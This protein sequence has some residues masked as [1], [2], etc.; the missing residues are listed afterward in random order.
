V[1]HDPYFREN[2]LCQPAKTLMNL[3]FTNKA[4]SG[5]KIQY[6]IAAASGLPFN[7]NFALQFSSRCV[8]A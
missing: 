1:Q 3:G 7:N 2:D 6:I 5:A 4:V 8:S